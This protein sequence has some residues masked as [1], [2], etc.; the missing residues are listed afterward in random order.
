M[1]TKEL[2]ILN[3]STG[4]VI[5]TLKEDTLESGREKILRA[6]H[7]FDDKKSHLALHQRINILEK[8]VL[9]LKEQKEKLALNIAQEGGKPLVDARIEANRAIAGIVNAIQV[10]SEH[11]GQVIP[12]G[13]QASSADRIS[14]TQKFPRGVVLAFSA[15]NHPLN[16]IIHQVIPAFASGCPC[17][18]KPAPDT[19]LSCLNLIK[20]MLEAGVPD[21]YISCVIT[22][23]LTLANDLVTSNKIAFFSFI[24]SSKVGWM[25]RSKLAPGVRCALEHGGV[26]PCIVTDSADLEVAIPSITKGGF[27]H[28]GQVC[29]ST[30]RIFVERT[31][32]TDFCQR[33]CQSVKALNVGDA[34][35]ET[36]D[37]GPLIRPEEVDRINNWVQE[38]IEQGATLAMGGE[39]ISGNFYQ[40]TILLNPPV[41]AKV[42]CQEI[43]GPV[44][45]VYPYDDIEQ[46]FSLAN[47]YPYA[48][49]A[50]I[51]TSEIN[52][53]HA[54]FQAF[55]A[56]A[57]MVN[58]H[59]AFRDDSMPFSGLS[60][61]GLGVGG[62]PYTIEEMQFEKML[63]M[64]MP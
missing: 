61:S 47:R 23:D 54:A 50:A 44:V 51:F 13:H 29:V 55:D 2:I 41:N 60:A 1:G 8:L 64:K 63:M 46:A 28:A 5:T 49:Q 19:P 53:M 45:C 4:E 3:P 15:F 59:T 36:T 22:S 35:K 11:R 25:L 58:D 9:I 30:Q 56:S 26:A 32:Y 10:I 57:V 48:F 17:V 12:L 52:T 18:I 7:Q 6:K 33:L 16:L 34:V 39:I 31:I 43:F 27:Y 38:A 42:S 14:F 21:D 24:G 40:P 37:V 20:A 62:I